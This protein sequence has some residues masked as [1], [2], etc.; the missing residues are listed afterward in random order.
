MCECVFVDLYVCVCQHVVES[1]EERS[2]N[3]DFLWQ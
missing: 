3:D 2:S 1:E